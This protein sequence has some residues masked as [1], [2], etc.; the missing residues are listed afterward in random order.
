MFLLF[1]ALLELPQATQTGQRT[2]FVD[3]LFTA[4]SALCVTG[5]TTVPTESQWSTFGLV[6]I[7]VAIKVGGLGVLTLASLLGLSVMRH[8][9][10]AQKVVTAKE[11]RAQQ[12][13]EVGGVL[14]TI[15]GA[16]FTA[17]AATALALLPVLL[18]REDDVV[19]AAFFSIFYA[20][21]AFNNAG[22]SPEVGQTSHYIDNP[23]FCIP[24]ATAI[25]IGSLGFPVI[26][27]L[28]KKW[29][30]PSRW[31]LH[32]KLTV[33]TSTLLLVGGTLFIL[34]LE[35]NNPGTLGP[36]SVDTKLL[37]SFFTSSVTR[38][39]GFSTLD[40]GA[41][42]RDTWL[43]MDVLM[44]IGAGSGST[45]GGIKVTTFALLMLSIVA[46]ARGDRD[47]EVFHRRVPHDTI[48][49]AI[50]VLV[51]SVLITLTATWLLLRFSEYSLDRI[52]FEVL[53]AFGSV[54]LT[55]GITPYLPTAG[56]Y[57][58]IACMYLGRIGPMTVGAA[59][60]LRTNRRIVRFAEERPIVG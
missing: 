8:M 1:T 27:V 31:T 53:S 7:L 42:N 18:G 12:L 57:V 23:F 21:S 39:A 26:L 13:S 10:L 44:F 24:V 6:V 52:V 33:L 30:T 36:L 40:L 32:A 3:A 58:I 49:Q 54:G 16:S 51:V 9:G 29:K 37:S 35:W 56:K 38:S 34:A 15:V 17:E 4:A 28:I 50:A 46:E 59:L 25:F 41:M 55:T 60:A 11:T 43:V 5:L 14:R 20:V 22:F 47:V 19:T 48:R 45:G 2:P